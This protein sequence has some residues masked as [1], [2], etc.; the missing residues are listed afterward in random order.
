[1]EDIQ[2]NAEAIPQGPGAAVCYEQTSGQVAAR[3]H[4]DQSCFWSH[5]LSPGK[6]TVHKLA[7]A[8]Y[9]SMSL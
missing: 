8:V 4:N 3:K 7:P 5:D 2:C 9:K 1:M 6:S